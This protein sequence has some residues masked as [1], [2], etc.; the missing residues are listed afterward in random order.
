M[1]VELQNGDRITIPEG[2]KAQINGNEVVIEKEEVQEFKDGDILVALINGRRCNIF[3]Y[4]GRNE[5]NLRCYYAGLDMNNKL[6]INK[7]IS[8]S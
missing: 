3:I 6:H 1:K 7:S 5:R 2:C 4:K 8:G